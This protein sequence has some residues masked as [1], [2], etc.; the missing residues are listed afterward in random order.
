L[1]VRKKIHSK[2][3][4]QTEIDMQNCDEI[5]VGGDYITESNEFE[6]MMTAED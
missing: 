2:S 3:S 1:K 4:R 6:K 5:R